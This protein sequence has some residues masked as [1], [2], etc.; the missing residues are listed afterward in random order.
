[1]DTKI[2]K[3][4]KKWKVKKAYRTVDLMNKVINS[5]K[6]EEKVVSYSFTDRRYSYSREDEWEEV[7]DNNRIYE[8][9]KKGNEQYN[10]RKNDYV[11]KLKIKLGRYLPQVGRREKDLI[12]TQ[13][14]FIKSST[15]KE[16]AA[17]WF[18]EYAHVLGFHHDYERTDRRPH[19]IPYGLGVIVEEVIS[20]MEKVSTE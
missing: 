18:H 17:H 7:T 11:W 2:Y 15:D 9:L 20:E 8:I 3:F 10:I 6:F 13:N 16:L 19:S 1:M 5:N 14:W 12:I 4:K